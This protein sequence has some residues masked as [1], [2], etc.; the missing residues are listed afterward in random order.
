LK[1]ITPKVNDWQLTYKVKEKEEEGKKVL[2]CR[3]FVEIQK[4]GD[5]F[6]AEFSRHGG[7]NTLFYLHLK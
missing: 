6:R 2:S 7:S 5:D 3:V 1:A 4:Y